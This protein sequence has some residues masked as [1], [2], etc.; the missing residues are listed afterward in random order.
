MLQDWLSDP[1]TVSLVR[2]KVSPAKYMHSSLQE[3][4]TKPPLRERRLS[5]KISLGITIPKAEAPQPQ[6]AEAPEPETSAADQKHLFDSEYEL[7][8]VIGNGSFG[9]VRCARKLVGNEL[10]AVKL[11]QSSDEELLV[12]FHREYLLLSTLHHPNIV[13]VR[14]FYS[15]RGWTA[16]V[17]EY[18]KGE[19]LSAALSKNPVGRF[20]ESKARGLFRGLIQAVAYLHEQ[21]VVHRDIKA[22]NIIIS[23]NLSPNLK[24]IDFGSAY[25][26]RAVND[27]PLT[28][29]PG[30]TLWA[31]PE[32]LLSR[33]PPSK[34]SDVWAAGLC[35]HMMVA[36]RLPSEHLCSASRHELGLA[37]SCLKVDL[38]LLTMNEVSNP[39]S[40]LLRE[41]LEISRS[42]RPTAAQV[43][44]HEWLAGQ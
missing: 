10:V 12:L 40:A 27:S 35:L 15:D 11:H 24:L 41:I 37:A 7:L 28:P 44:Q 36:G 23:A 6:V 5:F 26:L 32:V 39:C 16:I 18:V 22:T 8:Q 43:C 19:T 20:S 33:K 42:F 14:A 9:V 21:G 25:R 3:C 31:E 13:Q 38:D 30:S 1:S 34:S 17:T 2:K 4:Q 29:F